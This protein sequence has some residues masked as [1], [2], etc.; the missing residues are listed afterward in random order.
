MNKKIIALL[1]FKNEERFL[2]SYCS[3]I[4]SVVDGVVAI[5]DNS[6]DN[7]V[8][9]LEKCVNVPLFVSKA[10]KHTQ[11][12]VDKIRQKLLELGRKENG[13]HFVCLD[14]DEAFTGNFLPK[15]KKII[16][17][18]QPGQK[19]QM[20]WLAMWKSVNHYRDDSSVWSNSFKDFVF[21]DSPTYNF[22]EA[23]LC[24]PRTPGPNNDDTILKLNPKHGAVFH[25]QFSDF[26][27][28]QIKQAWYRCNEVIFGKHP[29][30]IN[31]KYNI[32][33]DSKSR[34]TSCPTRWLVGITL[35]EIELKNNLQTSWHLMEI[36]Q[37]FIKFGI[38]KFYS[39]DI[40][41]INE[42]N[43]LK[44]LINNETKDKKCTT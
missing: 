17:K 36:Y 37:K 33:L 4:N 2:K 22:G 24:E 27:M 3:S 42:I 5:D 12:S 7:S 13:T 14:A 11:W 8:K 29:K 28:F 30:D 18:L 20:Q 10:E 43:N 31:Q 23:F 40:W 15:A 32:T 21:C 34:I 35:P 19:L 6:T 38:E 41:H 1:P 44:L 39:L 9:I 16:Y 26:E 25:F